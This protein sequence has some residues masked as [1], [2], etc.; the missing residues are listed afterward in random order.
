MD[1]NAFLEYGK[2]LATL[3]QTAE[4]KSDVE[5]V[6]NAAISF[7]QQGQ[8]FDNGFSAENL[9]DNSESVPRLNRSFGPT[10]M[11]ASAM[12]DF[13]NECGITDPAKK[14]SLGLECMRI[15]S[16]DVNRQTILSEGQVPSGAGVLSQESFAGSWGANMLRGDRNHALEAFG[17]DIDRI[18]QDNGLSVIVTIL[19]AKG[20]LEDKLF[21]RIPEP[22]S[23]VTT[24]LTL[25][26][27]Y[28]LATS[29]N[30]DPSIRNNPAA[31][32]PLVGLFKEPDPV[33][34]QPVRMVPLAVNDTNAHDPSLYTGTTSLVVNKTITYAQLTYN[35]NRVGSDRFD[36]TDLVADGARIENLY[37]QLTPA[38]GSPELYI[39]PTL[40]MDGA[41]FTKATQQ[42]DSGDLVV[43]LINTFALRSGSLQ[44]DGKKAS[45][46]LASLNDVVVQL[47]VIFNAQMNQKTSVIT[48]GGSVNVTLVPAGSAKAVSSGTTAALKGLSAKIV[49][50]TPYMFFDEEN[51]RKTTTA[52]RVNYAERQFIIPMSRNFVCDYALAQGDDQN[53]STTLSTVVS[54]GNSAR[55]LA[56]MESRLRDVASALAFEAANPEITGLAPVW[57]QSLAGALCLPQ[58]ISVGL[59]FSDSRTAVMRESERAT[60]LH[61]RLRGRALSLLTTL[62]TNS[63]Y[64]CNLEEGEIPTFKVLAYNTLVD[65]L[66]D[67]PEYHSELA[68]QDTKKGDTSE[69]DVVMTLPNGYRLEVVRTTFT[70]YKNQMFLFPIRK[71]NPKHVTS[72]ATIRDR[73]QMV[74]QYTPQNGTGVARRYVTNS[75]E[76]LFVTN[77]LAGVI[78]VTGLEDQY[79]EADV[80]KNLAF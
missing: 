68:F 42:L 50:Y 35:S 2:N 39:M 4:A 59:D 11:S 52:V 64:L 8:F 43:N 27:V 44:A 18:Q 45:A 26:E 78:T 51:L 29:M 63:L 14:V 74:V 37:L 20:S 17:V 67:I 36:F 80:A 66:F 6:T 1:K 69:A 16:G 60:E 9:A 49:A 76:I 38:S 30:A 46:L 71:A 23:T 40:W 70:D 61:G 58:V 47:D 57:R 24:K 10:D 22:T 12:S 56:I 15:L 13:L 62:T 32:A 65:L 53:V 28:D 41:L 73:G 3:C 75:R 19:R 7:F 48:G 31:R 25:P 72:F 55:N 54:L 79:G 5:R 33:S 21:P 77:P 34:T